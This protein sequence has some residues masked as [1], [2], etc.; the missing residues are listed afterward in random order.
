MSSS[1]RLAIVAP[2]LACACASSAPPPRVA[3]AAPP[4]ATEEASLTEQVQVRVGGTLVAGDAPRVHVAD[5]GGPS[6]RLLR[7]E[8]GGASATLAVRAR[9]R[10][11]GASA[12]GAV[13]IERHAELDARVVLGADAWQEGDG[14]VAWNGRILGAEL[15]AHAGGD[16]GWLDGHAA[17]V[18]SAFTIVTTPRGQHLVQLIKGADGAAAPVRDAFVRHLAPAI[19]A[20]P[21]APVGVGARW[22]TR[23]ADASPVLGATLEHTAI[24]L[25][26][27]DDAGATLAVTVERFPL[28]DDAGLLPPDAPAP[29]IAAA[30]A[31][32]AQR[33]LDELRGTGTHEVVRGTIERPHAAPAQVRGAWTST[34]EA[35]GQ[36]ETADASHE[37]QLTMT[38]TI[39]IEPI[40]DGVTP[41]PG[42]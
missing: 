16:L 14:N 42:G 39:E 17:L 6:R 31:R 29:R 38:D 36:V 23:R 24:E 27:L 12:D 33:P 22:W 32:A 13:A 35:A 34:I 41:R 26:A 28:A 8:P 3:P 30:F 15:V 7:W 21:E 11:S 40:G 2:L 20:V 9:T 10:V 5:L 37:V 18:D 25:V 1:S 4:P 19:P